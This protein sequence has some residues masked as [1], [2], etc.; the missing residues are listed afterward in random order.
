MKILE[1]FLFS[2]VTSWV[3]EDLVE[4]IQSNKDAEELVLHINSMGGETLAGFTIYDILKLSKLK[5]TVKIE[6]IAASS[7]SLVALAGD[8]IEMTENSFFMIHYPWSGFVGNSEE[9]QARKELLDKLGDRCVDIYIKESGNSEEQVREW[10]KDSTY[11]NAEEA[12]AAG[13]VTS[14]SE[15]IEIAA[16]SDHIPDHIK[17]KI[18]GV[19]KTPENS[20]NNKGGSIMDELLKALGVETPEDALVKVGELRSQIVTISGV[21]AT[22]ENKVTALN[23]QLKIVR[24]ES[25]ESKVDAG[26]AN[27]EILPRHKEI[28]MEIA[29]ASLPK[30]DIWKAE[31]KKLIGFISGKIDLGILKT[32]NAGNIED[33]EIE[34]R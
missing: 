23:T 22:L 32:I 25:I 9:F 3:V 14:I 11:F 10:M 15:A 29:K 28:A 4:L 33:Q 17:A 8:T 19:H 16:L 5:V 24:D 20:I 2:D 30:F 31:Q 26:I 27:G 6:G 12:V 18:M 21:N 34:I 13:F 1:F 7:A